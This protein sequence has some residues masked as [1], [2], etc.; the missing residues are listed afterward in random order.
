MM[1]L[2]NYDG[3]LEFFINYQ[4]TSILSDE[5]EKGKKWGKAMQAIFVSNG[6][7]IANRQR[8]NIDS[9]KQTDD[10]NGEEDDTL[11][12]SIDEDEDNQ[13]EM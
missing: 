4:K 7:V 8:Y 1:P 2:D 5:W 13:V 9:G 11:S 6:T 3:K 12:I 10:E